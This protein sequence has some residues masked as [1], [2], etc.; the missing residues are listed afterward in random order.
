[1]SLFRRGPTRTEAEAATQGARNVLEILKLSRAN[2]ASAQSVLKEAEDHLSKD[3]FERAMDLAQKAERIATTLESE[4]RTATEARDLLRKHTERLRAM[5]VPD[6]DGEK[7]LDEV[8]TRARAT[9]DMEGVAVPDYAGALA[10]AGE[11]ANRT[12]ARV[13]LGENASD[14]LFVA[15]LAVDSAEDA[16]GPRQDAIVEAQG[17]LARARDEAQ[18]GQF[19]LAATDAAVAEK[20]ALSFAGRRRKAQETL[21]SVERLI[22]GLRIAGV[23]VAPVKNSLEIGKSFLDKGDVDTALEAINDAAQQAADLGTRFREALDR[24]SVATATIDALRAEGLS[25]EEAELSLKRADAAVREGNYALASACCEDVG[26]AAR[27]Q[28]DFRD[29]LR[30]AIDETRARLALLRDKGVAFVNDAEEMVE[31]AENE[32]ANHKYEATNEDIRIASLLLGPVRNPKAR[33]GAPT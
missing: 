10:V 26:L 15:E 21:A 8:R 19:E 6:L 5:G 12:A 14:L 24:I 7:A 16:G 22:V 28:R 20:I 18:R 9:R 11:A 4:Y 2:L 33:E 29:G 1:M 31:R 3:S 32:F 27:K 13:A 30:R 25:T 17:L 23:A